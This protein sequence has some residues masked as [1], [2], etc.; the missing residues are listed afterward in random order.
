MKKVKQVKVSI[1]DKIKESIE[2]KDI[3][4]TMGED[5][6]AVD[7]EVSMINLVEVVRSMT[8]IFYV[9]EHMRKE[10]P[11]YLFDEM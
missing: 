11:I 6:E 2:L 10:G 9:R 5:I 8:Q 7:E 3:E 4:T 1:E